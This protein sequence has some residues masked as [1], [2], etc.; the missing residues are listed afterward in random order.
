M[1][2]SKLIFGII[3]IVTGLTYLITS[4]Q[5]RKWNEGDLWDKSM[6][7]RGLVGGI[8]LILIGIVSI[9]IHYNKW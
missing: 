5:R 8:S 6:L 7:F 1:F 9:L 2:E 4:F 3:M